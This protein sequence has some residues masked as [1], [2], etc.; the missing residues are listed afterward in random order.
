MFHDNVS[1]SDADV[2]LACVA[3]YREGQNNHA[4]CITHDLQLYQD[5]QLVMLSA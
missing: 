2:Q 5:I 3:R 4:L 1:F